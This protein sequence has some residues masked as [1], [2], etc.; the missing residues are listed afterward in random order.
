MH[1]FYFIFNAP[2]S[3][4]LY[5]RVSPSLLILFFCCSFSSLYQ[6]CAMLCLVIQSCQT[7]CDPMDCSY[8]GSSAHGDSPGM[9]GL[10]CP[11]PGY[12]LNSASNSGLTD[13][14]RILLPTEPLG[15]TRILEWVAY[16]FSRVSFW[17]KNHTRSNA[18]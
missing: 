9:R 12:R 7:L 13:C 16:P 6:V 15:R 18:F 10:L 11:L 1:I 14:S 8:P 3:F 5:F 2:T 4:S 17:P